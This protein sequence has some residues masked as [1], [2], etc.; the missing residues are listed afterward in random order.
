[1]SPAH[2]VVVFLQLPPVVAVRHTVVVIPWPQYAA[3]VLG[4]QT[5]SPYIN[6]RWFTWLVF[7][8]FCVQVLW[9]TT[10]LYRS[11][12]LFLLHGALQQYTHWYNIDIS[13]NHGYKDLNPSS[14]ETGEDVKSYVISPGELIKVEEAGRWC[15]SKSLTIVFKGGL[16]RL[17]IS[18]FNEWRASFLF[19][20]VARLSLLHPG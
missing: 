14:L 5:A 3:L 15:D 1:M 13:W 7:L 4:Y 11:L 8:F 17:T 2:C 18:G 12:Q 20:Q 16:E 6:T 10:F 19:D 9:A